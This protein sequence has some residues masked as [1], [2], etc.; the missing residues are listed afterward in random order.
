MQIRLDANEHYHNTFSATAN[1][2]RYQVALDDMNRNG[3]NIVRVFIDGR[4]DTGKLK[5]APVTGAFS[6]V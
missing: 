3:F 5:S 6:M 4:A 1:F 2:T